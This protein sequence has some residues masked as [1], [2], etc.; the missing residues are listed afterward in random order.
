MVKPRVATCPFR[1][2]RCSRNPAVAGQNRSLSP[3]VSASD[4][5]PGP[6]NGERLSVGGGRP[7]GRRWAKDTPENPVPPHDRARDEKDRRSHPESCPDQLGAPSAK[8]SKVGVRE[9]V[10]DR[11]DRA[12]ARVGRRHRLDPVGERLKRIRVA[13]I[14]S[15]HHKEEDEGKAPET[16]GA[17]KIP[18]QPA[19]ADLSVGREAPTPQARA[20][21]PDRRAGECQQTIADIR[22]LSTVGSAAEVPPGVRTRTAPPTV[23]SAAEV[24]PA[25]RTRTAASTAQIGPSTCR[26]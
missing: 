9:P 26:L 21:P 13:E 19:P 15:R 1:I 12:K 25:V 2:V 3:R 17:V 8:S 22:G 6:S 20:W 14:G 18:G 7:L 10:G 23:G 16:K 5:G 4:F 24:P 11:I